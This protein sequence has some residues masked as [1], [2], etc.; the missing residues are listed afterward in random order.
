MAPLLW[1]KL[2]TSKRYI[3]VLISS[4]AEGNRVIADG[5]NYNEIILG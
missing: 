2:C 4:T 5:I 1:V 3:E